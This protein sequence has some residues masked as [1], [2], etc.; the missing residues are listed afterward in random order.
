MWQ[1][2]LKKSRKARTQYIYEWHFR[3]E[4]SPAPAEAD[5]GK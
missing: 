1:T 2:S 3:N 5:A 4:K